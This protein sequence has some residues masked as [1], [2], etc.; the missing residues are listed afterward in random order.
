LLEATEARRRKEADDLSAAGDLAEELGRLALA[1]EQAAAT[2][3]K[4]RCG[5]R[6]YLDIWRSN[7]WKVVGWAE[8]EIGGYHHAVAATWQTSVDQLTPG[9]HLLER[10]AF[11]APDPMPMFLLDV[12]VPGAEAVD[13]RDGLAD[14]TAVSLATLEIEGERFAVHRMV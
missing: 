7:R 2:I 9:R 5:F 4:L 14:L 3:D 11:L 12:S 1:L 8:L 13:L 6:R 10:L